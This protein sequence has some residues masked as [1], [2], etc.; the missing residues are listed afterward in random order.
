MGFR[1]SPLTICT[2]CRQLAHLLRFFAHLILFLRLI[3]RSSAA[4]IEPLPVASSTAILEAY[5]QVLQAHSQSADIIAFYCSSLEE[6][7]ATEAYA[8]YLFSEY[9]L[10]AN[11]TNSTGRSS[12][13]GE[14]Q[15]RRQAL[16]HAADNGLHLASVARRVVELTLA[17]V[18]TELPDFDAAN[19]AFGLLSP[20][21]AKETG[22]EREQE[23]IRSVEWLTFDAETYPDALRQANALMRYFLCESA[24]RACQT[25]R[26]HD[27]KC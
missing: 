18:Y 20:S 2:A 4:P 8:R 10:S 3:S 27:W 24:K 21:G 13:L 7:G 16:L 9:T 11:M 17:D 5:I 14:R 19:A 23:L 25:W 22:D 26:D 15:E 6:D 12:R 1:T